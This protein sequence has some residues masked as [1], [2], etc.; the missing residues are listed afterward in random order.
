MILRRKTISYR[1]GMMMGELFFDDYDCNK[2]GMSNSEWIDKK[3]LL[4]PARKEFE[5]IAADPLGSCQTP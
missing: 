2:S 1:D 4:R 5:S 3:E